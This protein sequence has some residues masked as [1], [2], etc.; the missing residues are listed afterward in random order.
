MEHTTN[1]DEIQPI[2]SDPDGTEFN[3]NNGNNGDVAVADAKHH[4]NSNGSNPPS[5]L[6]I[7]TQQLGASPSPSR[8]SSASS[9][10]PS[11]TIAVNLSL[12]V[13]VL[14]L[15]SKIAVFAMTFSYAV[16]A[17]L[18]DS[19]LDVL[20]QLI[21]FVTERKVRQH[22]HKKYP[23]GK[24]RLEPVGILT[25]SL[26][27]IMLSM[28][29]MRESITALVLGTHGITW[30][31]A[32]VIMLG[33]VIFLKFCLWLFCR[34]F[35]YSPIAM[36]LAQDHLN[37]VL[38]NAVAFVVLFIAA[39]YPNLSW[40]DPTGAIVISLWIIWSWYGTAK[41]EVKKLVGRRA[42]D[43]TLEE[44][45]KVCKTHHQSCTLD[46]LIGYHVG[47][48]FLIEVE[49]IMPKETTLEVTHD[50][51]IELQHKLEAFEYVER[52]FVHCD[53]KHRGFSEH[54]SPSLR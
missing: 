23:V 21:I 31:L 47:R 51:C 43:D 37:D 13:N 39:R 10:T 44:L 22:D 50:V 15:A 30:S 4:A 53:Y 42:D 19:V 46:V 17:S 33:G 9:L 49:M 54:K 38:S 34:R 1:L 35:T 41:D 12:A 3:V 27:M 11:V 40:L 24:T 26:L 6:H 28:S 18:V 48:N 45:R 16:I 14:L 32:A 7:D 8:S 20:S 29:V 5:S 52:A 2:K 36:A 25:V